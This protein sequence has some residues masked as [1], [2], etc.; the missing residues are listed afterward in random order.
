MHQKMWENY[1]KRE[2]AMVRANDIEAE[3][4]EINKA[5]LDKWEEYREKKIQLTSIFIKV[6]KKK[7]FLRR[8]LRMQKAG[9]IF[10]KIVENLKIRREYNRLKEMRFFVRIKCLTHYKYKFRKAYGPDMDDRKKN[11]IRRSLNFC[12][13]TRF[14]AIEDEKK[15]YFTKFLISTILAFQ[16]SKRTTSFI[17]NLLCVQ[18]IRSRIL[19]KREFMYELMFK[20]LKDQ[21]EFLI[22]FYQRKKSHKKS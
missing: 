13:V 1:N 9:Q 12:A 22:S 18:Q 15:R 3:N 20:R 17:R 8:Y 19:Q 7:N 10:T 2:E 11:E 21:A 5:N 6:L 14:M 16:S 4:Y